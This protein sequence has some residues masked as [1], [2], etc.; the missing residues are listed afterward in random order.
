MTTLSFY[1][2]GDGSSAN[3]AALNVENTSQQP[4]VLIT[5]DSGPTGDLVLEHNGGAND[6]DTTVTINGTSY[7][8]KV[9]LTG[10]LPTG[11]GK[12]P[13]PLEGKDITVISVVIGGSTERFFFVTDGSGSMSLMNQFG[14][15]AISLSN[16]NFSPPPVFICF[17]L[18]TEISTPS[19]YRKIETFR[20][21]DLVLNDRGEA[22]PILWIGKS[23]ASFAEMLHAPERRPVRIAS[24]DIAPSVPFSDLMVSSQHRV[25]L[26]DPAALLY[27][28]ERRVMVAA[29]HLVGLIAERVMPVAA[30][31]YYHLLLEE[32]ELVLSNGML[33]ESF[34][35]SL[36]AYRGLPQEMARSLS[37]RLSDYDL[38]EFFDRPDA[39]ISLKPHEA[40]AIVRAVQ[41]TGSR[42]RHIAEMA[43]RSNA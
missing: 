31:T 36:R 28:G 11:N 7:N 21:G 19:G 27:F 20:A 30:T 16:A 17:C 10:G 43:E 4:T 24:G 37:E 34:Q 26:D 40:G 5:F 42:M 22:K 23:E 6:P 38:Q 12:V 2:R 25:V 14:N 3:N 33:S 41:G 18:G 32:H 35:P 29:K 1:A 8:F 13:D 15:G 39:M 9:E